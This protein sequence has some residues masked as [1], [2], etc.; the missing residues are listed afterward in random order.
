MVVLANT[1]REFSI[2]VMIEQHTEGII[3][4]PAPTPEPDHVR[5]PHNT[6]YPTAQFARFM[7]SFADTTVVDVIEHRDVEPS[8]EALAMRDIARETIG[9]CGRICFNGCRLGE[10]IAADRSPLQVELNMSDDDRAKLHTVGTFLELSVFPDEVVDE[11][12][13]DEYEPDTEGVHLSRSEQHIKGVLEVSF[14]AE[15]AFDNNYYRALG[16]LC[17]SNFHV[18]KLLTAHLLTVAQ[19]Q[20]AQGREAAQRA[21]GFALEDATC[22]TASDLHK[23]LLQPKRDLHFMLN[24]KSTPKSEIFS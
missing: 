10:V 18:M 12:E 11:D 15:P 24:L 14:E 7:E 3:L 1:L 17:N 16:G 5:I 9:A 13:V 20:Q 19:A 23:L 4:P 2:E 22:I 21:H 6:C 8:A